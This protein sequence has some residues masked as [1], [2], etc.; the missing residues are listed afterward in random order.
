MKFLRGHIYIADLEP[1]RG[2]EQ[3]RTRPVVILSNDAINATSPV[4]TIVPLT[5]ASNVST[6][7][8]TDVFVAAPEAGLSVDSVILLSQ[9]RTIAKSRITK[10]LGVLSAARL[11]LMEY[12]ARFALDL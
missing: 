4:V 7:Y 9:I 10:E 11:S 8:R 12:A 2:S 5:S 6:L 1:V 3:G